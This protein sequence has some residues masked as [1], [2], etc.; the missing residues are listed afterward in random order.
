MSKNRGQG[1]TAQAAARITHDPTARARLQR[2]VLTVVVISQ[3]WAGRDWL[4][5]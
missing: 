2:R 1:P 4:P 5:A 3:A